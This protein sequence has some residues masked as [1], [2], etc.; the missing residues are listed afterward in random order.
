MD[1]YDSEYVDLDY[2]MAEYLELYR[3]ERQNRYA[4]LR[5]KMATRIKTFTKNNTYITGTDII[6]VSKERSNRMQHTI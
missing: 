3:S 6:D 4:L 1:D 2:L 5:K